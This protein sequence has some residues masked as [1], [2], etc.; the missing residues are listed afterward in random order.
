MERLQ[1]REFIHAISAAIFAADI[2]RSEK[3]PRDGR[4]QLIFKLK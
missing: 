1:Q 2:L 3:P 4:L